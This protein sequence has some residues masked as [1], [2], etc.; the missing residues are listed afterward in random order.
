MSCEWCLITQLYRLT[1]IQTI[2]LR[3]MPM[4]IL[5]NFVKQIKMH[6]DSEKGFQQN[7]M[8]PLHMQFIIELLNLAVYCKAGPPLN[9]FSRGGGGAGW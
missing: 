2:T 4:K 8:S 9:L 7:A 6:S 1:L 3:L 5:G